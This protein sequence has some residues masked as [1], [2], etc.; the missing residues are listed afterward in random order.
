MK[1]EPRIAKQYSYY[2]LQFIELSELSLVNR[3]LAQ[4]RTGF[5]QTSARL[6]DVAVPY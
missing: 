6:Q 5:K 1:I 3:Q 2:N 4:L